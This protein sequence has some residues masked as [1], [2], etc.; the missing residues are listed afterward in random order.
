MRKKVTI[1]LLITLALVFS[2]I[3]TDNTTIK[4]PQNS[5]RI[6]LVE[7]HLYENSEV[8]TPVFTFNQ[9]A[10]SKSQDIEIELPPELDIPL[11]ELY[12]EVVHGDEV[13]IARPPEQREV[14]TAI[15]L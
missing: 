6:K 4:I 5:K 15:C 2:G 7:V 13:I 1:I 9:I 12:V 11:E 14:F 8:D 3:A 10:V